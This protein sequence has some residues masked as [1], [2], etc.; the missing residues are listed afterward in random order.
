MGVMLLS[1]EIF[2]GRGEDDAEKLFGFRGSVLA[3]TILQVVVGR[4]QWEK[5]VAGVYYPVDEGLDSGQRLVV[6]S[7]DEPTVAKVP[8][9]QIQP[10]GDKFA[11]QFPLK[12]AD[13][14]HRA[15]I[16]LLIMQSSQDDLFAGA[17]GG[18]RP[19]L[20]AGSLP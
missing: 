6:G 1:G 4:A 18:G 15:F 3:A 19:R 17:A 12:G 16:S 2:P 5:P 20:E 10:V 14:A 8:T 13:G 11:G 9:E 7:S